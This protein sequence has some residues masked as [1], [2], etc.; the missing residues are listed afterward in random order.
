LLH[1]PRCRQILLGQESREKSTTLALRGVSKLSNFSISE[2][3]KLKGEQRNPKEKENANTIPSL[4][5]DLVPLFLFLTAKS[6]SPQ[7]HRKALLQN[8]YSNSFA[9][10]QSVSGV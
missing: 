2:T 5:L 1:I 8:A 3:L 6:D 10:S 9:A 7:R 4:L